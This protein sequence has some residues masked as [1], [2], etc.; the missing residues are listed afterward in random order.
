MR[1]ALTWLIAAS[2][3]SFAIGGMYRFAPDR[4]D[5]RWR[6][7][8]LGSCLATL[9]WL[10]AT[11]GFG[12]YAS[13]FGNYDATYGSLGA[14][15]VLLMWLFVSAYAVLIGGLINAEI[16]RQAPCDTSAGPTEAGGQR[17]GAR[18]LLQQQAHAR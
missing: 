1:Q 17:M 7:F 15:V 8:S 10:A 11:L 5:V 3:C 14:V 4:P 13:R 16:E 18:A 12:L 9:L 6:W 2:L